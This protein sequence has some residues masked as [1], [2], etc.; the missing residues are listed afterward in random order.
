MVVVYGMD[1]QVKS[2]DGYEMSSCLSTNL[3][4]NLYTCIHTQVYRHTKQALTL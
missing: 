3:N 2:L 4:T 1:P